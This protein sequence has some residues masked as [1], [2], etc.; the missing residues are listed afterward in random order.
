MNK[1]EFLELVSALQ[2]FYPKDDLLPD[3]Q[4]ILLWYDM[5]CDIPYSV[6]ESALRLWVA[7]NKWPPTIAELREYSLKASGSNVMDWEEAWQ[8][9]CRAIQRYGFMR[10]EEGLKSLSPTAAKAT[11]CLG[12]VNLCMSEDIVCDRANFRMAYENIARREKEEAVM[13]PKT[14]M[15][16]EALIG[17]RLQEAGSGK[18]LEEKNE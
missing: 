15:Q 1:K 13:D 6:L 10:P 5:L 16:I 11:K 2:T 17:S 3:T 8:E 7:N 4:S 9:V 12:W 14:R 18:M